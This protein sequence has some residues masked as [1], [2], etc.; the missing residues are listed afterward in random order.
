MFAHL[1]GCC[2]FKGR[3]RAKAQ[4][5]AKV[6]RIAKDAKDRDGARTAKVH[7]WFLSE[8]VLN[9]TLA[10][11]RCPRAAGPDAPSTVRV[12]SACRARGFGR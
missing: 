11:V 6:Q 1:K 4:R 5:T 10:F 3:F 12:S 7:K 9:I 2:R 8:S